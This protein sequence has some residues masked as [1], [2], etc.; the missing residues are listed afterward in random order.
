M[1]SIVVAPLQPVGAL[2][3]AATRLNPMLGVNG[4]THVLVTQALAA[5]RAGAVEFQGE[6]LQSE[7]DRIIQALDFLFTGF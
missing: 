1:E 2:P 4:R 6:N 5:V 7:R 3:N